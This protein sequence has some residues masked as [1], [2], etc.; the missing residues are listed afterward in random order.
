MLSLLKRSAKSALLGVLEQ[1]GLSLRENGLPP[2]GY[3][4]FLADYARRAGPPATVFDI[5]VGNGTAWLY[6]AFPKARFVLVEPQRGFKASIDAVLGRYDG[7]CQYCALGETEGEITLLV[8]VGAPTGA[9]ILP[10]DQGWA[11]H[12]SGELVEE[13]VP[14]RTLDAIAGTPASPYVVKID[15]E[16]A[17]LKVLRGGRVCV[18]AADMVLVEASVMRRHEGEADFVDIAAHLKGE[19]FRLADIV[20]MST[21]GPDKSLAYLDAAFVHVESRYWLADQ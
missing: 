2:R 6:E 15:A 21:T 14:L 5:G 8:P 4:A 1:R 20:E 13:R 7:V 9:S 10:R 12:K 17:E 3:A 16:G 18:R 11:K 19:G